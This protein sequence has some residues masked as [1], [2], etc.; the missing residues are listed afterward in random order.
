VK[1]VLII[2]VWLL[3]SG[4]RVEFAAYLPGWVEAQAGAC[5]T[6]AA[7]RCEMRVSAQAWEDGLVRGELRWEGGARPVIAPGGALEYDLRQAAPG[8]LRYETLPQDVSAAP[9]I[10]PAGGVNFI[11]LFMALVVLAGSV[12]AYRQGGRPS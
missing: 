1:T 8:E 3:R 7:G 4:A 6:D 9:Q 11:L 2:A 10:A 5:V 12:W